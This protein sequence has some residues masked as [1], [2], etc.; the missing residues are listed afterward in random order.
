MGARGEEIAHHIA[1]AMGLDFIDRDAIAGAAVRAGVS[2]RALEDNPEGAPTLG[3]QIG[4]IIGRYRARRLEEP[5]TPM[6]EVVRELAR[7]GDVVLIGQGAPYILRRGPGVLGVYFCG[8]RQFRLEWLMA[9]EK[10]TPAEA[11]RRLRDNDRVRSDYVRR[12]W[13]MEWSN[14]AVYDLCINTDWYDAESCVRLVTKALERL[15][16]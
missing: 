9:Q 4:A 14:P 16:R 11:E 2:E 8:S 15:K 10:C 6:D 5:D 13:Q 12:N 1:E 3:E 7:R